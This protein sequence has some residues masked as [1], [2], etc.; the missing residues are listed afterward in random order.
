MNRTFWRFLVFPLIKYLRLAI[1]VSLLI[2]SHL[3]AL[4]QIYAMPVFD[5]IETLLVKKL[6]FSPT[7]LLRFVV[8]NL[9]VGKHSPLHCHVIL[10]QDFDISTWD[11][12]W[13]N[14]MYHLFIAAFTMF[15][16]ITFPFFGGLLGFFG[17]FAFAPTTYFVSQNSLPSPRW[18]QYT[19]LKKLWFCRITIMANTDISL[20]H[21]SATL[22]HVACHLQTQEVQLILV[23]KL[24][25]FHFEY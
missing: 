7:R 2:S 15:I 9:Y 24:G 22:H 12:L 20:Q 6:N 18:N 19:V 3:F 25:M 1:I 4:M 11:L 21:F 13:I 16:G 8:R 23:Y 17:G 10:K 14:L 5:M